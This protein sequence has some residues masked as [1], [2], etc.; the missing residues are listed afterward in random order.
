[1]T[2]AFQASRDRDARDAV[3]ATGLDGPY[4]RAGPLADTKREPGHGDRLPD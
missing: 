3:F 1:M 2:D 4:R